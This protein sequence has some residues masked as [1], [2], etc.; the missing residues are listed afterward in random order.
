MPR[1]ASEASKRIEAAVRDWHGG[2]LRVAEISD[3][4][5]L[6]LNAS[7]RT[8]LT[9]LVNAGK[10]H[11]VGHGLYEATQNDRISAAE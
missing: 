7:F 3:L 6:P 5:G 8:I 4:A 9:S 11:R 1:P 10:F 2:P